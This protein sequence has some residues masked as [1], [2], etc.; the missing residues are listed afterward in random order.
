MGKL[1]LG[2]RIKCLI[3]PVR[4]AFVA[5][6]DPTGLLSGDAPSIRPNP[7]VVDAASYRPT[8]TA[9]GIATIFGYSL[10][11]TVASAAAVPF[12]TVLEGT[13]VTIGGIGVP[14]LYVSPSQINLQIPW[15]LAGQSQAT[16]VVTTGMGSSTAAT[17]NISDTAPAIFT[18]NGSGNGQGVVVDVRGQMA[19]AATPV[20]G[21]EYTQIY[22]LGPGAVANQPS[23]G[24]AVV[25]ASSPTLVMP[26]VTIAGVQVRASFAGLAPGFAGVYQVNAQVPP[27]ITPGSALPLTVRVNGAESQTVTIAV[28]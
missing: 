11:S 25:D 7:G 21:G 15:E 19:L 24:V 10:A 5:L 3:A 14:L 13:Q 4:N 1:S 27:G 20:A 23:T 22:C 26:I 16:V 8:V 9:G 6:I 17:I 18:A 2:C 28:Q 12:S